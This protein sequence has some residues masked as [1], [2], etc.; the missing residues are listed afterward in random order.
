[1]TKERE[2]FQWIDAEHAALWARGGD[3]LPESATP[4]EVESLLGQLAKERSEKAGGP[5]VGF[6]WGRS[7]ERWRDAFASWFYL[8]LSTT[9]LPS[10]TLIIE[11]DPTG[12]LPA[13]WLDRALALP[14]G[15]FANRVVIVKEAL[16]EKSSFRPRE[17]LDLLGTVAWGR[18]SSEKKKLQQAIKDNRVSAAALMQAE[19]SQRKIRHRSFQTPSGVENQHFFSP[20]EWLANTLAF[21]LPPRGGVGVKTKWAVFMTEQWVRQE[22]VGTAEKVSEA[23]AWASERWLWRYAVKKSAKGALGPEEKAFAALVNR[24]QLV[25][26]AAGVALPEK[27]DAAWRAVRSR[28]TADK[29]RKS[30]DKEKLSRDEKHTPKIAGE[31]IAARQT[32]LLNALRV[33]DFDALDWLTS[34]GGMHGENLL[35]HSKAMHGGPLDMLGFWTAT[36]AAESAAA[37]NCKKIEL[38]ERAQMDF[39]QEP[40]K[41]AYPR[42]VN[43]FLRGSDLCEMARSS[44]APA[45]SA[46]A[47]AQARSCQRAGMTSDDAREW[48]EE[49]MAAQKRAPRPLGM[50]NY[51]DAALAG[52]E[53]WQIKGTLLERDGKSDSEDGEASSGDSQGGKGQGAAL[54]AKRRGARL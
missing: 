40:K 20:E 10:G 4:R 8:T 22:P 15:S 51:F 41:G 23:I 14:P 26:Q 28:E 37:K 13:D 21:G 6:G 35:F 31:L 5:G 19:A 9:P 17:V 44:M 53:R 12:E 11:A 29:E 42:K 36:D 2:L 32:M 27:V 33:G 49:A 7:Q 54:A 43:P 24:A 39:V 52:I 50:Q 38:L 3:L 46:L 47:F 25:A 16:A 18:P 34:S 45:C 48:L 30:A 1:M